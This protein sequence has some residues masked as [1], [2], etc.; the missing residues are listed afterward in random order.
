MATGATEFID[1]T[2]ADS[3]IPE[4][5]SPYTLVARENAMVWADLVDRKYEENLK[6]GDVIHVNPVSNLTAQTKTKASNAAVTYETVTETA[7]DISIATWGYH[8]LAVE[9]IVTAQ[10]YKDQLELYAPKQGYALGLQIDDVLAG[11]PDDLS[12][13]T[14]VGTLAQEFTDDDWLLARQRLDD[15]DVPQD[16][17]FSVVSPKAEAGLLKLDRMVHQDYTVLHGGKASAARDRAYITSFIDVP[18][19][20]SVN[21][22]GTNAAGHDCFMGHKSC[23]ALVIQTKPKAWRQFDIDYLCHKVVV[24][25]LFGTKEMREDHG[26]YMKGP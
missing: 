3:F 26:I 21:V 1:S 15:A 2:T 14:A 20:K 10:A 16:G 7:V 17:R 11:L 18:I 12:S 5:W 24:E 6:Y 8:A 13:T 22:E 25:Q 4:N 19:Y 9:T 23:F